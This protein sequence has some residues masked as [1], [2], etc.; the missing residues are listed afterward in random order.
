MFHTSPQKITH[1]LNGR[2]DIARSMPKSIMN[3]MMDI[4]RL[5]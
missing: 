3:G 4:A 1:L 2:M 5:T